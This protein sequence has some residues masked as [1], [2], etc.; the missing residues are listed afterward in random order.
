M[1]QIRDNYHQ[2]EE[3]YSVVSSSSILWQDNSTAAHVLKL[4]IMDTA[5][6]I[7]QD[8]LEEVVSNVIFHETSSL[9]PYVY[10]DQ[11]LNVVID[12]HPSYDIIPSS[13]VAQEC[14][15]DTDESIQIS[16]APHIVDDDSTINDFADAL[17]HEVIENFLNEVQ[18]D[19]EEDELFLVLHPPTQEE[20]CT[21]IMV[22]QEEMTML[23]KEMADLQDCVEVSEANAEA[24][25]VELVKEKA[26][27]ESL[28]HELKEQMLLFSLKFQQQQETLNQLKN[29]I[30]KSQDEKQKDR[31]AFHKTAQALQKSLQ[32]KANV[33]KEKEES[34]SL[35]RK[36]AMDLVAR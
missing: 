23:E 29:D 34:N 1:K 26:K 25:H 35:L 10:I 3:S 4:E 28:Q 6:D 18:P 27:V 19:N 8:I 15:H 13:E 9:V 16:Q 11:E 33:L 36:E 22:D 5:E 24:A 2:V 7:V 21:E 12:D 20:T 30:K 31:E 32:D 14:F 17:A